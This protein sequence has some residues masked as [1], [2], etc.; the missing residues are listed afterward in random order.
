MIAALSEEQKQLMSDS[1]TEMN[2]LE[3]TFKST[4]KP[5]TPPWDM[6]VACVDGASEAD[7]VFIVALLP[8]KVATRP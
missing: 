7:P 2:Q 1:F 8:F 3:H 5:C 6:L 4:F